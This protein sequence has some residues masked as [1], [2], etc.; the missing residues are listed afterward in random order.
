MINNSEQLIVRDLETKFKEG[1]YKGW[2]FVYVSMIIFFS[3]GFGAIVSIYCE[4]LIKAF[5]EKWT[6]NAWIPVSFLL[7][8]LVLIL[9]FSIL[10]LRVLSRLQNAPEIKLIKFPP[11]WNAYYLFLFKKSSKGWFISHKK[12]KEIANEYFRRD[13]VPFAGKTIKIKPEY[14][15]LTFNKPVDLYDLPVYVFMSASFTIEFNGDPEPLHFYRCYGRSQEKMA[16]FEDDL[17]KIVNKD[18]ITYYFDTCFSAA[19]TNYEIEN[20]AEKGLDATRYI[21]EKTLEAVR[22]KCCGKAVSLKIP[23]SYKINEVKYID[24]KIILTS[25]SAQVNRIK[26]SGP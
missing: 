10:A 17:Y 13:Y 15:G 6:T 8:F 22:E 7:F 9:I 16:K 2:I 20:K 5:F 18:L 23:F 4:D 3:I 1:E 21:V 26:N 14:K 19:K 24:I 12:G 25:L 11:G